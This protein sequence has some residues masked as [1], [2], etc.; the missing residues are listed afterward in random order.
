MWFIYI[1]LVGNVL[2]LGTVRVITNQ[3]IYYKYLKDDKI[4][5]VI[6]VGSAGTGKTIGACKVGVNSLKDKILITRPTI[7]VDEDI[8]YLPGNINKKMSPW[9]KPITDILKDFNINK[10]YVEISPLGFMRGR[11]FSNYFIIADEMQNSTPNQMLMLLTRM[12]EG[13]KLV[14]TGDLDQSDN[15]E[16][17]LKDLLN[18]LEIFYDEEDE[19]NRDGIAVVRFTNYDIKRSYIVKKIIR[20]YD[21]NF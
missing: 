20:I 14:I 17:G 18:R 21:N 19:M 7:S 15:T 12:G 9:L 13:S 10:N 8:G 4:K 16:N 3:E 2:S 1:L 5:V 11:T 6:S